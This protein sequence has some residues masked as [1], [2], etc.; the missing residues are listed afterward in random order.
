M[1]MP[2]FAAGVDYTQETFFLDGVERDSFHDLHLTEIFNIAGRCPVLSIPAGRSSDGVPIGMQ[3][4]GP[5]YR[6]DVVMR[7][8]AAVEAAAPWP[9]VAP[10]RPRL[11]ISR[12]S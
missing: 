2:A 4:V 5:T 8:G 12:R 6:D 11:P 1:A 10:V 3:I 7:V 9:L